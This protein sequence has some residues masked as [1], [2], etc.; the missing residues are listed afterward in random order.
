MAQRKLT[1][2]FVG[3][4]SAVAAKLEQQMREYEA[5]GFEN[6]SPRQ[7]RLYGSWTPAA[8][9]AHRAALQP[10]HRPVSS[11]RCASR[12]RTSRARSR[13]PQADVPTTTQTLT[14]V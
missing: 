2:S 13:S 11:A 14:I 12:R 3:G 10:R 8:Y 4:W 9:M 6:F 1:I 5:S 7:R